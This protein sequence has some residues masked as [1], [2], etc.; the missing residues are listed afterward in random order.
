MSIQLILCSSHWTTSRTSMN[1]YEG[2]TVTPL[3]SVGTAP[4]VTVAAPP[5]TNDR[6]AKTPR[7][8]LKPMNAASGVGKE[9]RDTH[10]YTLP[11]PAVEPTPSPGVSTGDEDAHDP[12]TTPPEVPL[13]LSAALLGNAGERSL[14]RLNKGDLSNLFTFAAMVAGALL[15]LFGAHR[16]FANY[17]TS[18]GLFGYSHTCVPS[19][20]RLTHAPS[21][22]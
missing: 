15:S 1:E 18:F 7:V 2:V 20:L 10:D 5:T 6:D 8:Q 21:Q 9:A 16:V 4:P 19:G 12:I 11:G 14:P 3:A 22:P 13:V 17:V